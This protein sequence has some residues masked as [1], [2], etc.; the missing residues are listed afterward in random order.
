MKPSSSSSLR[1]LAT[2]F[3]GRRLAVAALVVSS[4]LGGLCEAA[5]LATVAQAAGALVDGAR[6]VH[7]NFGSLHLTETVGAL[8]AIGLALAVARLLLQAPL[9]I[10]PARIAADVQARLQAGLFVAYTRASWT[11]QAH[12]REGDLQ[13]LMTNQILQA[14]YGTLSATGLVTA[15]LTLVV[16]LCS[17]LLLNALAT[18]VVACAAILLLALLRPLNRLTSRSSRSQSQAQM[19]LASGVGQAARLAEETHVF[20]VDA[21][22]R[23]HMDEW[24]TSTRTFFFQTQM[25]GRL[26]PSIYQSAIY[27]LVVAG[28]SVIAAAHSSHV[29]AL[30]AVVLLLVRA[31]SYGQGVQGSYQSL[32]QALPF[33]ERVQQAEQRYANSAPVTGERRL[34]DIASVALHGVAFAYTAARPVLRDLSFAVEGGETIGIVGPSGAGKST[35]V[36]ILLRLRSP[37]RGSYLVNG[38]PATEFLDADWHHAVAYVPQDPKLLHASVAD[39]IS[40]FR[41]VPRDVVEQAARLAR[42]H[43][44]IA[45]WPNGYDTIIGPRA[46][47]VSGGQQQRIC[48]ARALVARPSVLILD[49]PTSALDPRSES[50]LQESLT[51]LKD[52]MTLFIV[53]HRISTLDICDRVMVIVEGQLEAFD[54]APSLRQRN[55]YYRF[56]STLATGMVQ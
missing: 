22:Q 42:I 33:V 3:G 43:D 7:V 6:R 8:L 10:L 47:A 23:S 27:L 34:T 11:E 19:N 37:D 4:V 21:A 17:A 30:G 40:Y 44:D 13:E 36:Q 9:S 49:E 51:T 56:A 28:L 54:T 5:I 20:G 26:G 14:A 25:L 29:A 24:I 31:G 18:L 1:Q 32:R 41:S 39:N 16:L 48:I 45:S 50:L 35:L 12:D 52:G 15:V 2:L 38:R 53:A 55:A 46:D